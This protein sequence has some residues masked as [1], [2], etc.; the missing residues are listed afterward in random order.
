MT[1]SW[2]LDL[3]ERRKFLDLTQEALAEIVGVSREHIGLVER[4]QEVASPKLRLDIEQELE[5]RAVLGHCKQTDCADCQR[6]RCPKEVLIDYVTMRFPHTVKGATGDGDEHGCIKDIWESV[7]GI[8][9]N[10]RL[11]Y[12][13]DKKFHNYTALYQ[14]FDI[15]LR[16][17]PQFDSGVLLEM[18]GKGC[19]TFEAILQAQGRD[20]YDF[21][22]RCLEKQGNITRL[23]IA[24]DDTIGLLSIPELIAK[25][26]QGFFDFGRMQSVD[27]H[28]S[29][30]P[31]RLLE[32]AEAGT[33]NMGA[34]LTI[35][36]PRSPIR[37]CF[38]EK[39]YEQAKKQGRPLGEMLG[40]RNRVE[41]R[42]RD[43]RAQN[44]LE[45][46]V[47]QRDVGGL[48]YGIV[49]DRLHFLACPR[50]E[51][52]AN[53]DWEKIQL[54]TKPEEYTDERSWRWFVN[55]C[56]PTLKYHMVLDIMRDTDY[57]N[58]AVRGAKLSSR[59]RAMLKQSGIEAS[60]V[61]LP[62]LLLPVGTVE[63]YEMGSFDQLGIY[64]NI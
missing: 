32:D 54:T 11:M 38:Y 44:A 46:L 34:T 51:R 14:I 1:D 3:D 37:F 45:Y 64:D 2:H 4:G 27:Y 26:K 21:F 48:A 36:S 53:E 58:D 18:R 31:D 24:I 42:L 55:Q 61:I 41:I 7:L 57:V 8:H 50:W 63:Q 12:R 28:E 30:L 17:S 40:V 49:N 43:D 20:W 62:E 60:Q 19:R 15:T 35:G 56:A 10:D 16:F 39:N 9:M 25:H 33:S 23:D 5:V 6:V 52:F 29:T 47:S 59:H 13:E 22:D